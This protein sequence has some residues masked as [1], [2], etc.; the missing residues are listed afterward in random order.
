[1][2]F[3]FS[4]YLGHA[5]AVR[6]SHERRLSES[7]GRLRNLSAQLMTAQEEERR[8][9][10]RDLHDEMGQ[11][12]T[13]MTLD[14]Q[15]AAAASE[16]DK[17]ND[18][19]GRALHGAERLLDTI[20]EIAARVRPSLLDDLGLKDAVQSF[21]SDYEHRTGVAVHADLKFERGDIPAGVSENVYRILQESLTN[22][23][24]HAHATEVAV[25]LHAS[26]DRVML[27]VRDNGAGFA[28]AKV[29]GKRLGLLG[30]RE[31]AELLNGVFTVQSEPGKGTELFVEL[32]LV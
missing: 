14:L 4:W 20:H 18:L 17:K 27:T 9:I 6:R 5:G 29:D 1:L 24:K 10:A 16:R 21:L 28:I 15:R 26:A 32:P 12:V 30:M 13:A 22:V 2:V 23:S 11:V 19:I 31:R 8:N 25:N 3:G 7:E